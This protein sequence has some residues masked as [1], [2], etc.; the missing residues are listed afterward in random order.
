MANPETERPRILRVFISYA[1]EDAKIAIAV[2][3]ALQT[4]LGD[5][6]VEIFL[7]KFSLEPGFEFKPQIEETLDNTDILILIY[8][9]KPSHF[10]GFE[11]GYFRKNLRN[12]NNNSLIE[13]K[14]IPL[15]LHEGPPLTV[16]GV[17]GIDLSISR[18]TLYLSKEE[19]INQLVVDSSNQV[20]RFIDELNGVLDKIREKYGFPRRNHVDTVNCVRGMLEDIFLYLKTTVDKILKPQKQIIIKTNAASIEATDGN[21]PDNATLIPV[22]S[23][24]PMSIFGLP[25]EEIQW[26]KFV[27]YTSGNYFGDSWRESINNVVVS[28]LPNQ[29]EI[30]NSQIIITADGHNI[31]RLILTT[32][33]TYFN[34][35]KEFNLYLVESLRVMDYGDEDTTLLLKGLQLVCRF[36]FIFLEKRSQFHYSNILLQQPDKIYIL[37][38]LMIKE[39]N[40]IIRY[41]K[42]AGLDDPQVWRQFVTFD[43]LLKMN[44]VWTP[45]EKKIRE[46]AAK[47]SCDRNDKIKLDTHRKEFADLVIELEK[48]IKPLNGIIIKEMSE[49]L[50]EFVGI[51]SANFGDIGERATDPARTGN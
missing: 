11:I 6:L 35:N 8:T 34:G 49:K 42:D 41:A 5:T 4:A 38:N 25:E 9:G 43:N 23:G 24:R 40:L 45:I 39:L 37:S 47:I 51:G 28:S 29:I 1:H 2:S 33:T 3:N 21:L 50:K 36:R 14:I 10:M 30:D 26:S 17:Q 44:E 7:D 32:N 22:G 46:M 16:V 27:S 48:N 15:C 19:F 12:K 20:V 31:Y 13:R 18:E